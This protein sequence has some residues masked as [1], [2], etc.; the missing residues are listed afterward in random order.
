MSGREDASRAGT[1]LAFASRAPGEVLDPPLIMSLG[2]WDEV[3][4]V[5][6]ADQGHFAIRASQVW[7]WQATAREFLCAGNCLLDWYEPIL[8]KTG[9]AQPTESF[10]SSFA[11]MMLLYATAA[12][13]LLKAIRIAQGQE[14]VADGRLHRTLCSHALVKY[15][16]DAKIDLTPDGRELLIKLRDLLEAGKYPV[17]KTPER[18]RG[19]WVFE[20]PRDLERVWAMLELLEDHLR[21]TGVHC[22]PKFDIRGFCR[23]PPVPAEG[24]GAP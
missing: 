1:R 4:S 5:A 2:E 9:A 14:P 16:E 10:F 21:A 23:R 24:A 6:D 19:A 18:S 7:R 22:F 20:Y 13:N 12:E 3:D 11:P 17:A 8:T 15:A